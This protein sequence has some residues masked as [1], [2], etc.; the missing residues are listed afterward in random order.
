MRK[1]EIL[2]KLLIVLLTIF[3][4][5]GVVAIF[6]SGHRKS[7][8]RQQK[9]QEALEAIERATAV[10]PTPVVTATP[11][12]TPTPV[13][14]ATPTP[15]PTILPAFQP[16]DYWDYWYSTDGYL[17][18]N[19]YDISLKK[20][21]FIV[22]QKNG[23]GDVIAQADVTAEVAGNSAKLAFTDS[24]GNYVTGTMIFDRGQLYMKLVTQ[25]QVTDPAP[26]V[27]CVMQREQPYVEWQ[28]A[29]TPT[30]VPT[31][32]PKVVQDGDYIIPES[33]SRYLTDEELAGY[34]IEQLELAR[35]EI[36]ARH[37][38]IFVTDYIS[39]Y[40]NSKSWYQGT[41]APEEFD[42]Q[43]GSIFNEYEMENINKLSEWEDRKRN[44]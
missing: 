30:P 27:D 33:S 36:F 3:F 25:E 14:T 43:M 20:A 31:Q 12:P 42:A 18:V 11:S 37:G 24:Q 28:S 8:E 22:S 41:V 40:F 1:K 9:R 6:L 38:R 16:D 2:K 17:T 4:L 13:P 44:E 26:H 35:N 19:I 39:Q 32:T 10:T 21:A 34:S 15:I 23:Y 5:L 29:A 7:V